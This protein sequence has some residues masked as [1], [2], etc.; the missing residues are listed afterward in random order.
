MKN[1]KNENTKGKNKNN[2]RKIQR[3][4]GVSLIF[5]DV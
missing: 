3:K 1:V 5:L 2:Q 4:D